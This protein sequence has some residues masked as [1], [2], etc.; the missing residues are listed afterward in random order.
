[1]V[2][3]L[4]VMAASGGTLAGLSAFSPAVAVGCVVT[5]SAGV[6]LISKA[7]LT[8][9]AETV[10]TFLI[11]GLRSARR[12]RRCGLPAA[13]MVWGVRRDPARPTCSGRGGGGGAGAGPPGARGREP[14]GR[15]SRA[16]ED[17]PGDP[18]RA[19]AFTGRRLGQPAGGRGPARDAARDSR[20]SEVVQAM[21]C[22]ERAVAF[23]RDGMTETRRAIIALREGSDVA[24]TR[25]A[26]R[27]GTGASG[28]RGRR[29]STWPGW[30]GCAR[31]GPAAGADP[32]GG[33]A[34]GAGRRLPGRRQRDRR[35]RASAAAAGGAEAALTAYRTAQEALT[36]ARKHAPGEPVTLGVTFAPAPLRCGSS[37]CCRPPSAAGPLAR[38]GGRVRADRAA[39]A[40]RAGRRH[41]HRRTGRWTMEGD[42]RIPV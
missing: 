34:A 7:S 30:A 11:A 35:V 29:G 18:R 4:A 36:N 6:R 39:G 37:T 27:P 2:T 3:A 42:L 41:A 19:R 1:M 33:G 32:A 26:R 17:R 5:S 15:A 21:E 8:I 10:A 20:G 12:P 14:R 38:A 13:I 25:R 40:G 22:I 9:T 24:A 16:G 28:A 23:T 31:A